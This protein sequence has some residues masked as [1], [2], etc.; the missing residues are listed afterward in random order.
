M[1]YTFHDVNI[2]AFDVHSVP[3][4]LANPGCV[5]PAFGFLVDGD[6]YRAQYDAGAAAQ[7]AN[8]TVRPLTQRTLAHNRF[9]MRY[10]DLWFVNGKLDYWSL[11]LPFVGRPLH[12]R[13]KLAATGP[14][15]RASV[16]P[17]IY[18][19]ALGWSTNIHVHLSGDISPAQLT[20]LIGRLHTAKDIFLLGGAPKSLIDM[21][22]LFAGWVRNEVYS[23]G[24]APID[25]ESLS[26]Y[27]VTSVTEFQGPL[28]YYKSPGGP[29]AQMSDAD[30]SLML[31]LLRGSPKTLQDYAKEVAEKRFTPTYSTNRPDFGLIDFNRGALVFMQEAALRQA[32]AGAAANQGKLRCHGSNTRLCLM[33]IY[34]LLASYDALETAALADQKIAALRNSLQATLK[35][36]PKIY[37]RNLFCQA[38]YANHKQLQKLTS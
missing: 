35:G 24:C 17:V 25:R 37:E 9:W 32:A 31:G 29:F 34:S 2:F 26:K 22:R 1:A 20:D 4:A 8:L 16:R 10:K 6:Q 5:Q 38:L 27:V 14:G 28:S 21:F 13:L 19:S 30:R 33:M 12:A 3:K 15:F 36:L 7:T 18:L 11:Q 23:P